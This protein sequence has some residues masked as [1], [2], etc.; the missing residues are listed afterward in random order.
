M[1]FQ[2]VRK[3]ANQRGRKLL[4]AVII[5][6]SSFAISACAHAAQGVPGKDAAYVVDAN[7]GKI[8]YSR[9]S[10]KA[11]YPA[12]LTKVMTIYIMLEEIHAGR[13]NFKTKIAMTKRGAAQQPSKL[14][15]KVGQTITASD[16]IKALVVKSAND[17]AVAVAEHISGTEWKFTRRMTE[18][19]KRLGMN[20]TAF[21]NANG[22]PNDKQKT[23]ARDMVTMGR[24]LYRD[25]PQHLG[26]FRTKEFTFAGK[27]FR[28]YNRLVGTVKGVDGI[29]TGYIRASGYNLLASQ[30]QGNKHVIA[31]VMGGKTGAARNEEMKRLLR[32]GLKKA[33]KTA[34]APKPQPIIS[35]A[36]ASPKE[37]STP[38]DIIEGTIA[39][40]SASEKGDW[41]VQIGAV[42]TQKDGERLVKQT[43][44]KLG[45]LVEGLSATF[46]KV[47]ANGSTLYR[48]RFSNLSREYAL[49]MC[50][51]MKARK[52]DCY[53]V[54]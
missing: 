51:E 17:V 33:S 2:R 7:T 37:A 22:L 15:M 31:V 14:G 12:S 20:N 28:N 24:A 44:S 16:A 3:N 36:Y 42:K 29:K 5:L 52:V 27:T 46:P 6:F 43:R 26:F 25:F 19:A 45:S 9:S 35:T 48:V 38:M 47:N 23:T 41:S 21:Y 40:M 39:T 53:A 34:S 30:R 32:I 8:L 50:N 4:S 54:K 10:N 49:Q 1:W 18:T 13:M 11:R